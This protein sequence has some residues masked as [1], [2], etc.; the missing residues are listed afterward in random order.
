MLKKSLVALSG[1]LALSSGAMSAQLPNDGGAAQKIDVRADGAPSD[2]G[3]LPGQR[4]GNPANR[5]RYRYYNGRWWYFH[6]NNQWSYWN[7]NTWARY[8]ASALRDTQTFGDAGGAYS[9]SGRRAAGTIQREKNDVRPQAEKYGLREPLTIQRQKNETGWQSPE[10][11]NIRP[12]GTIQ[13]EKND[14]R[15]R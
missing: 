9:S 5:W 14:S 10:P 6:P 13:S 1:L 2:N 4:G 12:P 3:A 11:F 7:G 8:S 15:A